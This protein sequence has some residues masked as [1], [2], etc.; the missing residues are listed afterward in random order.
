LKLNNSSHPPEQNMPDP[1]LRT[2]LS[3]LE[4]T[5]AP[6]TR[7]GVANFVIIAVGWIQTFGVH[8]VTQALVVTGVAGQRHHEAFHRFFSRGAW[9]PDE[10]GRC[11]FLRLERWLGDGAVRICIDDTVAPK[12]GPQVF[13]IGSHLDAVRSTRRRR[14][15]CF[16]HCWVVLAVLVNVPFS[17]RVWALPVL[18]RL[19]RNKKECA[20]HD[21]DYQKKTELARQLIDVFV[22]WTDRRI[23]L[24]ADSAYCNAT[25]TRGLCRRVVL[26]GAMRPDAVLTSLPSSTAV[27]SRRGR[28]RKRGNPL[29]KPERVA[30]DERR[31]WQSTQL[32][33]YGRKTTVR[34]KTLTAQWYRACGTRLLRIVVVATPQGAVPWRV[35]FCTDVSLSV[36]QI[37]A[38]YGARW[39]IECFFREAKQLLGF[40]D[41]SARKEAAVLRVAPFVGIL[42]S[43]LVIWFI[44]G[45]STSPLAAPPVRPWYT[46]KRGLSFEDILRAARRTLVNFDVLVPSRDINNLHQRAVRDGNTERDPGWRAHRAA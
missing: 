31:P 41:S 46:H 28:P 24:A 45:A 30:Q 16:G 2:L 13:G 6:L 44:E 14:V 19:Y 5:G 35:F 7:P 20:A 27:G 3:I 4:A 10:L 40:G 1:I 11:L 26:F 12:K 25:V 23:E 43:V 37:L 38:G 17:A 32:V 34:Y 15:F 39:S 29:P 8:A 21:G 33:L 42:Y 36:P 22:T 9:D 18:F